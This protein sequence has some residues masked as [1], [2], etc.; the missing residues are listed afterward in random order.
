MLNMIDCYCKH[1]DRDLD[2]RPH[3]ASGIDFVLLKCRRC[4]ALAVEGPDGFAVD[5]AWLTPSRMD[6][7]EMAAHLDMLIVKSRGPAPPVV[8]NKK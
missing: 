2:R 1:K 3:R 4:D 7:R 5:G 8:E 6:A